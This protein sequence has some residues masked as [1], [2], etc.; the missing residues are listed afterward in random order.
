MHDSGACFK[1]GSKQS[2]CWVSPGMSVMTVTATDADDAIDSY[3]GVVTYSILS[4]EPEP[5]KQMFTINNE[6][7]LIS[8]VVSGLDREVNAGC[9]DR[10]NGGPSRWG[11]IMGRAAFLLSILYCFTRVSKGRIIVSPK[12]SYC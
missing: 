11:L 9:W 10:L 5:E 6:T 1:G 7:G 2:L 12:G 8:V 4:Q 3:N